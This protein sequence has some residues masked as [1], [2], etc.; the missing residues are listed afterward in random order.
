[1]PAHIAM[2]THPGRPQAT[3]RT[4]QLAAGPAP[5][6]HAS[7]LAP[8]MPRLHA[9][10]ITAP[11]MP[12]LHAPSITPP[13][14]PRLHAPRMPRLAA[15]RRPHVVAG[16]RRHR[17]AIVL[18]ALAAVLAAGVYAFVANNS[19]TSRAAGASAALG[20]GYTVSSQAIYTFSSDGKS[21][22]AVTFELDK[23][24]SDVEVALAAGTPGNA[25]WTDCGASEETAPFDVVCTF[26]APIR[27]TKGLKLSVAAVSS[28]TVSIDS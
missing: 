10:S 2:L 8:R 26:G 1:M 6:L 23:A 17:T 9:P 4:P 25:A 12:R 5:R 15:G 16:L 11:R 24:A 3:A 13:R 28:G 20:S 21:M 18:L 14:L 27:D 22:T 7:R 19:L